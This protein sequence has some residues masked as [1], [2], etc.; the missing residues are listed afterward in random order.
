MLLIL[1]KEAL[2]VILCLW[3]LVFNDVQFLPS[4]LVLSSSTRIIPRI[5]FNNSLDLILSL[6]LG[7]TSSLLGASNSF[8]FI[9]E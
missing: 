4:L 5:F 6:I 7:L 1:G 9:H 8:D 2:L 3:I